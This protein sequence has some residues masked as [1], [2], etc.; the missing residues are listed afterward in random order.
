VHHRKYR[1]IIGFLVAPLALYI[2]FVVSPNIQAVLYSFTDWS[3]YSQTQ[4]F[5]GVDN[6]VRLLHDSSFWTALGNN[7][8]LLLVLPIVTITLGLVFAFM[9]NLGGRRRGAV[10]RGLRGS[11]FYSAVYFFPYLLSV[12]IIAVLWQQAYNP[13]G[14]IVP[15]TMSA[16]GID[17]PRDG[18]LGTPSTALWACVGVAVWH[19]VG[20]YVVLF[21]AGIASIPRDIFEAAALDGVNRFTLLFRVVVPL[22]W[23]NVQVAFVYLGIIALDFFAIVNIMT[24]HPEAVGDSTE[25]IAHYLFTRA[26]SGDS[27]PQYGYASA[28]GVALFFLTLTLA[29]VMFRAS[30]RE[31]VEYS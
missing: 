17:P 14:G 13:Q 27:N 9:I 7:G 16:V 28:I 4:N 26:F 31:K 10:V 21:S 29:A 11:R 5:I 8:L 24:P 3:G 18:L 6:Y 12:A 2:L 19:A 20:F 25:V 23:D 1:F 30:R 22:L 15:R